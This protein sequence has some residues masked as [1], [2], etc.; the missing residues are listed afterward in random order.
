[1][2]TLNLLTHNPVR[3]ICDYFHIWEPWKFRLENVHT[4]GN[5]L[6]SC[7]LVKTSGGVNKIIHIN[8]VDGIGHII[9]DVEECLNTKF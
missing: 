9:S 3:V 8:H 5:H 6:Q 7:D 1:M 4:T 2:G